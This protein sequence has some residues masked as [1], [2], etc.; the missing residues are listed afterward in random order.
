MPGE[1][2]RPC[3][4]RSWTPSVNP[5]PDHMGRCHA[6]SRRLAA[7]IANWRNGKEPLYSKGVAIIA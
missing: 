4:R 7:D 2:R 1:R 6:Q 3:R 5:Q